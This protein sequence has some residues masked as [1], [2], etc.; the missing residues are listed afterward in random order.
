MALPGALLS[1]SSPFML[2]AKT[3]T[4]DPQ[5]PDKQPSRQVSY[6]CI[7]QPNRIIINNY[8]WLVSWTSKR[9]DGWYNCTVCPI[10]DYSGDNN[11]IN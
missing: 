7:T 11:R 5:I 4:R 1:D 6:L 10:I 2:T 3:L 8:H 9:Q